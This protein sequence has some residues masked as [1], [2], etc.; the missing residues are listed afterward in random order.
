MIMWILMGLTAVAAFFYG[1]YYQQK[2]ANL[3]TEVSRLTAQL[4]QE[5]ADSKDRAARYEGVIADLKSRLTT[6]E[7]NIYVSQN[8]DD[9][10]R[11]FTQL[12]PSAS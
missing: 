6:L 8:P 2:A 9:I 5:Q 11:L 10:R 12:F 3:Q 1:R 7:D 4:A